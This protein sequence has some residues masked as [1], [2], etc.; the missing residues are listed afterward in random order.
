MRLAA[1][2]SHRAGLRTLL[3]PL[4]CPAHLHPNPHVQGSYGFVRFKSHADAVRAIVGMN[5]Q[6]R[7]ARSALLWR[8]ESGQPPLLFA[9]AA[10]ILLLVAVHAGIP[11]KVGFRSAA[12]R[13]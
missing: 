3:T 12:A 8:A 1:V 13:S 4:A 2:R 11:L 5:G 7:G 9:A 10:A 6:V